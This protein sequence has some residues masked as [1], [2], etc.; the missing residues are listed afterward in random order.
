MTAYR[1]LIPYL[2]PGFWPLAV[3]ISLLVLV[4]FLQ[5][6]I[7]RF[8]KG[9]VDAL[10]S[11]RATTG[12]LVETLA[13]ILGVSLVIFTF[14]FLWRRLIFGQ[15]RR[16]EEALRNRLV[17][18]LFLLS[19]AF[20]QRRPIGDL[21]A[22]A[23]N[24][25]EAVRMALGMGLVSLVDSVFLGCAAIG[26]MIYISP[27]LTAA[28]LLP[29]P[30]V[31]YLTY[32][33]SR[34][35][36][37]KFES[38]QVLFSGLM[39]SVR[40]SLVGILVVKAYNLQ[41]RE[42]GRLSELSGKY[43]EKN[44]QL[45]RITGTLFPLSLLLT[46]LSLA[47]VLWLGGIQ[48]YQKKITTGDFVAFISYLGMLG[49]PV[50]ALGW[51]VNLLKRGGVSLERI[52]R[53]LDE[54]PEIA[55]RPGSM[56]PPAPIRKIIIHN[57]TFNYPGDSLSVLKDLNLEIAAGQ[58]LL[59]TGRTGSGKTTLAQ[60]LV[61]LYD[62]PAGTIVLDEQAIQEIPL[63]LLRSTISLVP[64]IPFLFSDT[65]RANLLMAQPE[66]DEAQL[67]K[68]LSLAALE[69]E[70]RSFPEGLD[71]VVGEKGV[72]LSGGQRQRLA[73]ARAFLFQPPFLILD[74]TLAS[75]DLNTE[76]QIL[77][78]LKSRRQGLTTIFISHRL[79][80]LESVD[81]I[82][83]FEAGRIAESGRHQALMEQQ[84]RY[85]HLYRRQCLEKEIREGGF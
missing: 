70:V 11:G 45:A 72:L 46:N 80:G 12:D 63:G 28:A 15:A 66:A 31:A 37:K 1:I 74:N 3:G 9:A 55:D 19:P 8:I 69:K 34:V 24:D 49:W 21:M 25:M 71:T 73:L 75:V 17:G 60:L 23:T 32:R 51:V 56:V 64:Q 30:L 5:L 48:V 40:E 7:P 42:L 35:F 84:G 50:M 76:R 61:R 79:V 53:L 59:F 62:S 82:F 57:L 38:V 47:V 44:L 14:R 4:D 58:Q 22:H 54:K 20:F 77:E 18:H 43:L 85:F 6:L 26:F 78:S 81:G 33:L 83:L 2:R 13:L 41:S 65:L 27:G 29:M 36:H 67:W 68:A 52:G 39:E 16:I 10:S